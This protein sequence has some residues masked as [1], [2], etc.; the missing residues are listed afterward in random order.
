MFDHIHTAI[1]AWALA[2]PHTKDAIVFCAAK[3]I[4]LLAAPNRGC[5]QVFVN[6]GLEKY[7]VL[8]Q[9]GLRLPHRLVDTA[10]WRAAVA[11]Y[12]GRCVEAA[13]LVALGL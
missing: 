5:R 13:L 6:T 12:K 4:G 10:H 2:I 9:P 7:V 8:I 3:E 11:R 1:Y